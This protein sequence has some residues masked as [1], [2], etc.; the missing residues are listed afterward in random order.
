MNPSSNPGISLPE[1]ATQAPVLVCIVSMNDGRWLKR[2]LASLIPARG[3]IDVAVVANACN[4]DTEEICATAPLNVSVIRTSR[5]LGFAASNNLCLE[6][7]LADDYEYVFLL[8]A[9]TQNHLET[10]ATLLR[11]MREHPEHGVSGSLQMEYGDES[12]T[13]LNRWSVETLDHAKS[14]GRRQQTDGRFTWI[15]H[16]YVQG[17]ALMLRLSV[18]RVIGLLDPVYGSFYEETDLCRRCWLAGHKVALVLDSKVQHYGG[19]NWKKSAE[20][21]HNRDRLFL[22]N[23]FLYYVSDADSRPSMCVAAIRVVIRQLK[24]VWLHREE[25]TLPPWRY[26][27]VLWSILVRW[28][29]L[30]QLCRRNQIVRSG[31]TVP[32]SLFK[33]GDE[34]SR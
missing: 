33:I 7:A 19:G 26:G 29:H 18:A 1:P 9:D 11:F 12:W 16:D 5:V 32:S 27:A 31:R 6:K 8:N 24:A 22:R 13:R 14:L 15:E 17:A 20:T 2:C 25:V 34:R 23:Q 28:R 10:I 30:R 4:D 21:R 3:V